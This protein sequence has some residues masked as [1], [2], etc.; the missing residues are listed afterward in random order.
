MKAFTEAVGFVQA[1][2]FKGTLRF[3]YDLEFTG[4]EPTI[5]ALLES[6]MGRI[7]ERARM[8]GSGRFDLEVADAH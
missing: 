5:R 4:V 8:R 3:D 2:R 1:N 6:Q 7:P